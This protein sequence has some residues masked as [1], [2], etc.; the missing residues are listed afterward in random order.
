MQKSIGRR[1]FLK[2]TGVS[3]SGALLLWACRNNVPI[4]LP[5]HTIEAPTRQPTSTVTPLPSSTPTPVMEFKLSS[6]DYPPKV[7]E[8]IE[9]GEFDYQIES[10]KKW[11][12]YWMGAANSPEL[13]QAGIQKNFEVIIKWD[14]SKR[15]TEVTPD[16]VEVLLQIPEDRFIYFPK[17]IGEF[18]YRIDAPPIPEGD[19]TLGEGDFYFELSGGDRDLEMAWR[20]RDWVR[21]DI[22]S[23][24]GQ[25]IQFV[26][27]GGKWQFV[28]SLGFLAIIKRGTE[29]FDKPEQ[30]FGYDTSTG[31]IKFK[32]LVIGD[33]EAN[34]DDQYK[35]KVTV[36]TD[37][38]EIILGEHGRPVT[39]IEE[40]R[41]EG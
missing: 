5:T 8:M 24:T 11:V 13:F 1:D 6:G 39:A 2:L 35:G 29:K 16:D 41:L 36:N 17:K 25:V 22:T 26:D 30:L 9:V 20:N 14:R 38:N 21:V 31:D 23:D 7:V 3:V 40:Q 4:E 32:N 10:F 37:D 15:E 12:E 18:G 33:Y 27:N 19:Y 28:N 34:P